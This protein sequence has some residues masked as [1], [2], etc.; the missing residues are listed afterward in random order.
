MK[1]NKPGEPNEY[2]KNSFKSF[3]KES[4]QAF[5]DGFDI[6]VLPEGQLNPTP[7]KGLMPLFSGAFALARMSRRPIQMIALHGVNKLWHPNDGMEVG[8]MNVTGRHVKI[9]V[10]PGARKYESDEDFKETFSAVAGHFGKYGTDV[11][12]LEQWLDGTKWTEIDQQRKAEAEAKAKAIA[13][14][15]A[16]AKAE[17]E[18]KAK[19]EAEAKAKLEEA[20]NALKEEITEE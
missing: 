20:E 16:K 5:V 12:D 7:E 11:E 14:A 2:D 3:L 15:E 18:A 9:R 8:D 6:G 10:Y 19:A 4:K 13:E 17:A 1:P